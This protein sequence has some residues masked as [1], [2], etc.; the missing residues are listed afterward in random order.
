MSKF[1]NAYYDDRHL[2]FVQRGGGEVRLRRVRAPITCFVHERDMSR[3]LYRAMRDSF[4][5][6]KIARDGLWWRIDWIDRDSRQSMC[7]ALHKRGVKTYEGSVSPLR[8]LAADKDIEVD[9]PRRVY[10]D[11]ETDSRV[12]FSKKEDA[13]VLC[14][15][16]VREDGGKVCRVLKADTDEA[17]RELLAELWR[18][19]G[20]FDQVLAWNGDRFDFPLIKERTKRRGLEVNHKRWLWLDHLELFRRMNMMAAESGDEKQSMALQNIAMAVLGEGKDDFDASKTWEAWSA[21]DEQRRRM[22]RYCVKDTDL[23]RRIEEKTGYVELLQTLCE[24]TGTF[25]DSRGI[26]PG[27]QVENFLLRLALERDF[28]FE[29]RF[30]DPT[31]KK[32]KGAFVMEPTERGIVKDVHVADFKSLYPS[33]ILSWNMSPE[34]RGVGDERCIAALTEVEFATDREGIL[35]VAVA[36]MV[37]L[38]Q[39]WKDEKKKH[40]PGS[41]AWKEADRRST[42]YKIAA[43]SFYGVVSSPLSRFF[44]RDVGQSV[45][46]CGAWLLQQTIKVAEERGMRV[47]YGDTDSLFVAG[48][49]EHEFRVFVKWC[50]TELYPKLLAAKSCKRNDIVLDY[51]KAFERIVFVTAKRYAGKYSHYGGTKATADSKPEVKGLEF[52]RGDSAR[53]TRTFQAEVVEL[54]MG[55]CEDADEFEKIVVE[56][57]RRVL[58][59]DLALDDVVIAKR[60]SKPIRQYIR[61]RKKDGEYARQSPHVEVARVLEARGH[62]V[63]EGARIAYVCV[64]GRTPKT[65]I[66]AEDFNGTVDRYDLWEALVW[67]A[68]RRVLAAAFPAHPWDVWDKVRPR[69]PRRAKPVPREQMALP[70]GQAPPD[71]V[72]D[73]GS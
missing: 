73:A 43:N 55:G 5:V 46:Q 30:V 49:T 28:H 6:K 63:G 58:E 32:F 22:A 2:V 56:H 7:E 62:D 12:P 40:P 3:G 35:A 57:K 24:A 33:I 72:Q 50:N 41:P 29:T 48:C 17:E 26:N 68:S 27:A 51:E 45:T 20:Y 70:W 47:V 52:K 19:L 64:D 42:A 39:K 16:L 71:G 38:R 66:P 60:L 31:R 9:K 67:R 59:G 18:L 34:T 53:L 1:L 13:R 8:R 15:A 36:E 10:L 44:D 14:W 4:R 21:G 54:L 69:Q 65:Y 61:K 11:I 37:K 25:P 23:M